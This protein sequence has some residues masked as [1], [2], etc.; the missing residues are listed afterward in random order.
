MAIKNPVR[1]KAT[2]ASGPPPAYSKNPSAFPLTQQ[3][4]QQLMS[5]IPTSTSKTSRAPLSTPT[6]VQPTQGKTTPFDTVR[7]EGYINGVLYRDHN[8]Y[9]RVAASSGNV[10]LSPLEQVNQTIQDSFKKLQDEVVK[11]FGEYRAGRPFRIDEVLAE[12][13]SAAAEQIDPYYNQ[14]LG[15]YLTGVT[16][17]I[18]RGVDDTR[19]LLSELSASTE[20][21]NEASQNTLVQAVQKAQEGFAEAGLFESGEAMRTE[22]QMKQRVGA[23]LGEFGRQSAFKQKQLNLGLERNLQDIGLEKKGYV[24]DLER[25]RFTDIETRKS[26]LGKEAG[27][28]YIRGFQAT[29]P[30]ELQSASGF[31]MLKS[32]GI[33]S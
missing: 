31:D 29:L 7:N 2:S 17:K 15:D 27:Q 8:E 14:I 21:Y 10:A 12:K 25:R 30:P 13:S 16:R 18:N 24:S 3:A 26:Q 9:R 23:D 33:Y 6:P 19:D 11:R 20:S 1:G 32:L 22:G 28:D 4:L 5:P